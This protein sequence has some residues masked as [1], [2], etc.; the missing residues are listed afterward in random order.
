M[1]LVKDH[2]SGFETGDTAGFLDGSYLDQLS[3]SLAS[4]PIPTK[5]G[6]TI[7]MIVV[8]F[9]CCCCVFCWQVHRSDFGISSTHTSHLTITSSVSQ[10]EQSSVLSV[11][12]ADNKALLPA[13]RIVSLAT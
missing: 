10:L 8:L 6:S 4:I 13:Q 7:R 1:Q 11:Q 5:A 3:S 9:C 12:Q 2:R